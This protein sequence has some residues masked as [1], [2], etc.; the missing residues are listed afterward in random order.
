MKL[1]IDITKDT[2]LS[3][4]AVDIL[5]D[6]YML[7]EEETP[8]EAF[9]RACMAFADNKAH[10]E[11][12]Y[13]Y[14]SNLWFM[15]ASPLLSNGGTDR[16]LPISCFLNYV[17]DSR[18]GLAA[19]YTENI[20][21]SSMG[22]GIGGYWGH[23][24]SQG[25]STSKGN[26][27][28]GVIPF[29]HVVDSQMVAFNQGATRRGSYAS[30][31]DVSHPEIIEFIEMRKPAGG[32]VN[33]KNLNLHH[34]VITPD[35]FMRAVEDDKDWDLIDPNSKEKVKT[36]KARSI[37]I[38]ILEARVATGEP[39][40]MFIDTVN[41]HLPKELKDKGLKVHHSNLCSEITLPTNEDRTAV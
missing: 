5:R 33:R 6:R 7:P 30:Y 14:V 23:I 28:T 8:Q 13:K 34:A 36:V 12:L 9:A 15:F 21:L 1:N 2:L 4:N 16:G 32:D 10:A 37:W 19:H 40:I 41:K 39:Y 20:W 31:M 18:E 24:R 29:M 22:G 3:K 27:T 11:R 17:P 38:K 35:K 25:Q 26:K